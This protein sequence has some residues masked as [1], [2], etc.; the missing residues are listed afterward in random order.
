MSAMG[1]RFV[2]DW[3]VVRHRLGLAA[4]PGMPVIDYHGSRLVADDRRDVVWQSLW[5]T[6]SAPWSGR[7]IVC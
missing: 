4:H 1:G 3:H 7:M 6:A 5:R 2:W